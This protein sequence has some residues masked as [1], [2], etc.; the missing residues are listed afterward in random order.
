MNRKE[1]FSLYVR[2]AAWIKDRDSAPSR[3]K[4]IEPRI[5]DVRHPRQKS[6]D[7]CFI[8]FASATDR[9]ETYDKLKSH[10]EL[11]VKQST[12]DVPKQLEK[13]KKIV[14]EKREAK[15]ETRKLVAKIKKKEKSNE[16]HKEKTNQIIIVNLPHQVTVN[17]LKQQ[18]P[19]AVKVIVKKNPK[20]KTMHTA[21][22]TFP[23]TNEAFEASKESILLHGQKINVMLNKDAS[24]KQQTVNK[25]KGK[26]KG[27][28]KLKRKPTTGE[29]IGEPQKKTPKVEAN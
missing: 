19:K 7:Y 2:G 20:A 14:S 9:D 8:D 22:I 5:Q 23:D 3:L 1:R 28:G 13:R 16:S 21:I 18:Y 29:E 25:S 11:M 15:K 4:E 10:P 26:G 27:K 6:A 17:E 12:K 24:F